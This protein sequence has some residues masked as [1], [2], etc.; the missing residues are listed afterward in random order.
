MSM[1][2]TVYLVDLGV[3][4]SEDNEEFGAYSNVY[5]HKH[6]YYDEN[7]FYIAD[8]NKAIRVA[9]DYVNTGVD[10]TY[11]VVLK[12]E[13]DYDISDDQLE[14]IS[15]EGEDYDPSDVVFNIAKIDGVVTENFIV[16]V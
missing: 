4:L 11:G 2:R 15:V 13:M 3:L 1:F 9:T 14:D 5:D 8:K 10:N 12:T 7:Q 6:G 16:E